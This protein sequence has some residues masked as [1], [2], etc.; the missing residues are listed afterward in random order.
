MFDFFIGVGVGLIYKFGGVYVF[1]KV[2]G[3][4]IKISRGVL[5]F[6]WFMGVLVFFDDYINI[7]IV[8]NI[9][10]LIIDRMRVFRE[11]LV[12]I[13]DLIV[14]LV[15]GFVLILMWIG[16]EL[17]MIGKGFD[18]VGIIYNFYDVWFL[19]FLFR[20]YLILVII[21]VFIVVYIY[22]YYGLMFYVEYCVR[23]MGKVFCDGVKLF[24]IIEIDFGVL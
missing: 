7:I 17:V 22:R 18:G 10:R 11:M 16:Y 1:V 15:V 24:M 2:F 9:M 4:R 13:D 5:V 3:S 20:F 21:L 14:V 19:S 12:Y 23:I 8:G 6:G